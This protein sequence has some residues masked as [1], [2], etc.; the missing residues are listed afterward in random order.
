MTAFMVINKSTK[1]MFVMKFSSLDNIHPWRT[2]P[3]M[4][5]TTLKERESA[6]GPTSSRHL[7]LLEV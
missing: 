1:V 6:S 3:V 4:T 2:F 5:T 7:F